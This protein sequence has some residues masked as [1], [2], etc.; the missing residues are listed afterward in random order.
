MLGHITIMINMQEYLEAGFTMDQ[1]RLLVQRDQHV[2]ETLLQ[3]FAALQEATNRGFASLLSTMQAGFA[4]I[5]A[6]FASVELGIAQLR[7]AV[8]DIKAHLREPGPN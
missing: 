5:E 7:T 4:A 3:G 1:A 2:H 6:R 8:E